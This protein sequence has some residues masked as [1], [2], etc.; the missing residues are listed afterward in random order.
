MVFV[1]QGPIDVQGTNLPIVRGFGAD[2]QIRTLSNEFEGILKLRAERLKSLRQPL[3]K[4]GEYI[5]DEHIPLQYSLMGSPEP[6]PNLSPR[7]AI[8]KRRRWGQKPMLV[9]SGRMYRG[10]S[11]NASR[12]NLVIRNTQD[13]AKY[14]QYGTRRMPARKWLQLGTRRDY[15]VLRGHVRDYVLATAGERYG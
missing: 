8:Q 12:K 3:A 10:F 11:F 5:V 7:Y 13:Y 1:R 6:W 4:F 2:I 9:A 14:H 15:P